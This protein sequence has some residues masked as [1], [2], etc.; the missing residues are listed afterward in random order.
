VHASNLPE[1]P[2]SGVYCL[3]GEDAFFL[4]EAVRK[5]S[6]NTD[7]LNIHVF[8]KGA[9]FSDAVGSLYSFPLGEGRV[10]V[11]VKDD[12]MGNNK[13]NHAMLEDIIAGG[14]EPNVLVLVNPTLDSK[15]KKQVNVVICDKLKEAECAKVAKGFF[16]AGIDAVALER[17]VRYTNGDLMRIKN[18]SEKL[19]AYTKGGKVNAEIVESLV[20]EDAEVQV[21]NFANSLIAGN[22]ALAIKQL[23]KLKKRG[24]SNSAMLSMLISQFRRMLHASIS[25]KT[26]DELSQIFKV[27]K[28]AIQKARETRGYGAVKLKGIIDMLTGYE[29]KFKSGEMSEAAAFD[30]AI[31]RLLAKEVN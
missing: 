4:S 12:L 24:E 21:Y 18:E 8:D 23:E 31:A 17:L 22:N 11:I 7:K 20:C 13:P 16:A 3:V 1:N 5:F 14:I 6:Q 26:D 29:L 2:E 10:V 27:H 25:K 28:F 19:N 9:T 30:A 15:E